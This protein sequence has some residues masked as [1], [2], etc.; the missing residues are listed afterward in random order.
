MSRLL[1]RGSEWDVELLYRF[2]NVIAD[3]AAEFGLD[4]YPNQIEIINSQQ[5]LEAYATSG[6]PLGYHHWSF[7]KQFIDAERA[8]RQGHMCLAYE[9]VINSD[10]CI[11]YLMEENSIA[12]QA[13]VIAHAC[14]GHNAFFKGNYCF[15][16]NTDAEAIIDYLVFAKN[17]ISE[18]EER[19][20]ISAVEN[21]LDACHALKNYGVHRYGQPQHP[22]QTEQRLQQQQ[23]SRD[24]QWQQN[25]IWRT[26]PKSEAEESP[27]AEQSHENILYY[28]EK[29]APLLDDWQREIIRIVRKIAQYF[30]PQRQTKVMNEGFASF[31]HYHIMQTLF[32]RGYVTEEFMLEFIDSHTSVLFQPGFDSPLYNGLNPYALGY[33]IYMDIKRICK[34][35]TQEDELWFPHLAGTD[36]L[37]GIDYAMRNFKDESFIAQYLSPHLCRDLHLFALENDDQKS[38]YVITAIH[39]E[40]GYQHLRDCLARQFDLA[41]TEPNITVQ[42]S[43]DANGRHLT[44]HYA[45][46]QRRPLAE[47][48]NEILHHLYHLW[49]YPVHLISYAEN[50]DV[51][52]QVTVPPHPSEANKD[53]SSG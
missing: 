26:L 31:W 3:I 35:P 34:E 21:V 42:E 16:E 5:M 44:L 39:D 48:T 9:I 40:H 7:G 13:L 22:S 28:L 38:E 52:A 15:R 50:G 32:E 45:Q 10:P 27:A 33:K 19:Y 53:S 43:D 11:A 46:Y 2:D 51:V 24:E 37:Q 49:G 25:E 8:Y 6:L 18:C 14:Y 36:W 17:Y 23:R 1:T 12:M 29:H 41:L 20:G 4:T 30:Y 47:N